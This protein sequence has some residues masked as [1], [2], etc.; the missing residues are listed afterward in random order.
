MFSIECVYLS[1]VWKDHVLH[2]IVFYFAL[3]QYNL[4]LLCLFSSF[5]SC[6]RTSILWATTTS[7]VISW[8]WPNFTLPCLHPGPNI[9]F[10][11]SMWYRYWGST[12]HWAR[13]YRI[14]L[15][16][17]CVNS[18]CIWDILLKLFLLMFHVSCLNL[19]KYIHAIEVY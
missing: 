10:I 2:R 18:A 13:L 7:R 19:R 16:R 17:V 1:L 9:L 11:K 5:S 6:V 3:P 12:M 15:I 4:V 14:D 8:S